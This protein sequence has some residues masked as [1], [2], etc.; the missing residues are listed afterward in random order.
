MQF[1]TTSGASA[2]N[3]LIPD[4]FLCWAMLTMRGMKK[5]NSLNKDDKYSQYA[6]L[7]LTIAAK[8]PFERKKLWTKVGD[9]DYADNT[10]GFRD[11]GMTSLTRMVEA[12]GLVNP[13][14]PA[15]Y[16]RLSGKSCQEVMLMLDGKYVAIKV[17]IEKGGEGYQDKNDV[18][19]YLT[20]N[21]QSS[22]YKNY[23]KLVGGDHGVTVG[24]AGPARAAPGGFAPAPV[25]AQPSAPGGFQ[26][27]EQIADQRERPLEVQPATSP[28]PISTQMS[29][30]NS[31]FNPNSAPA[32]LTNAQR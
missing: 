22:S 4:G 11:M 10:K 31:G 21:E 20:P 13:K 19:D 18:G 32:F 9:P 30:S 5:G 25:V 15:S 29:P 28:A 2:P 3:D 24:G 14:D 27:R 6:D 8:Q 1:S 17:K 12:A 16:D 23:V 26:Q 7:E